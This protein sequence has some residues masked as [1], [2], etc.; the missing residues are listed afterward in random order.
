MYRARWLAAEDPHGSGRPIASSCA[1]RRHYITTSECQIP[2]CAARP[3]RPPAPAEASET[4]RMQRRY[5][6]TDITISRTG[7]CSR[8]PPASSPL[9]IH[10]IVY[11]QRPWQVAIPRHDHR[12]AEWPDRRMGTET[13]LRWLTVATAAAAR[14]ATTRGVVSTRTVAHGRLLFT[15]TTESS[16]VERWSF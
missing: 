16:S 14:R 3:G 5:L 10:L 4:T 11:Q 9:A 7:G 13:L 1:R 6:R 8:S 12:C 2:S 15:V